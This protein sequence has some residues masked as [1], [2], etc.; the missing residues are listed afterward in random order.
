MRESLF[1]TKFPSTSQHSYRYFR[2]FRKNPQNNSEIA[3]IRYAQKKQGISL[4]TL[5]QKAQRCQRVRKRDISAEFSS[6]LKVAPASELLPFRLGSPQFDTEPS[7]MERSSPRKS[8]SSSLGLLDGFH[9]VTR[10]APSLLRV[11]K[12]SWFCG[13]Y[14]LRV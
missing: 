6:F 12:S 11:I 5:C 3:G 10:L 1:F 4:E 13:G 9:T 7:V 2:Q 14:S 8:S